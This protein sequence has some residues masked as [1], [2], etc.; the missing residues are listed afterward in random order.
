MQIST[1]VSQWEVPTEEAPGLPTPGPTPAPED[2]LFQ[3]PQEIPPEA[4][5][6]VDGD[7][8]LGVSALR[9]PAA[10]RFQ[11]CDADM[12]HKEHGNKHDDERKTGRP[13]QQ[14]WFRGYGRLP[15]RWLLAFWP[16]LI[17][18]LRRSAR[19]YARWTQQAVRSRSAYARRTKWTV[20][21][22]R[23]C[24]NELTSWW[25]TK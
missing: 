16:R 18:R 13:G 1:G 23:R 17:R 19:K 9:L 12:N 14:W 15:T 7:R 24:P 3:R 6:V 25:L 10:S 11:A 21:W 20:L 4:R 22:R 8:G 2:A 5:D